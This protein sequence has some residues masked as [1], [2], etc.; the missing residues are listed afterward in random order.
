MIFFTGYNLILC[1]MFVIAYYIVPKKVRFCVLA[2]ASATFVL[3][4][5]PVRSIL[6]L[7]ASVFLIYGCAI[8][9]E[10][11]NKIIK[12]I[13]FVLGLVFSL[14]TMGLL[15]T[16]V[17]LT[18]LWQ[19]IL[20]PLGLSY[21]TFTM[22]GYLIDVKREMFKAEKNPVKFLLFAVFFP[23][24][25]SGPIINYEAMKDKLFE[26]HSFDLQKI[27]FGAQRIIWGLFK[28]IVISDRIGVVVNQIFDNYTEY[29]GFYII[30]AILF[31][32]IQ[33]YTDFSGCIDMIM[34]IA[35][36]FGVD[37]PDNFSLP[38]L[39][40]SVAEFWRRWHITLGNWLRDYVFYTILRAKFV[41]KLTKKFK[42]KVSTKKI[43]KYV[44]WCALLVTWF[45]IGLWHNGVPG[46]IFGVGIYFGVIIVLSEAT[47]GIRSK[48]VKALR[49]KTDCFSYDLFAI[50]RTYVL[51][52]VGNMFFRQR[53]GLMAGFTMLKNIFP[54][55]NI[56][57]F[58]DGSMNALG[59]DGFEWSILAIAIL[60]MIVAGLI[61]AKHEEGVRVWINNQNVLFSYLVWLVI[62]VLCILWGWY[63]EGYTSQAFIYQQF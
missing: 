16:F 5:N 43:M 46:S 63:G 10:K 44:T 23:T 1:C 39:S 56:W 62:I 20:A 51:F 48:A 60:I 21:Y 18:P 61:R 13:L 15:K 3:I 52:A 55:N 37:L 28:K 24:L 45:C 9:I 4:V 11:G 17:N 47:E 38:F 49:I 29:S 19:Y 53:A 12:N 25:L 32:P 30:I 31:F 41:K 7:F 57:I 22:M 34:G 50:C 54:L 40:K 33:L 42:Q 6:F 59:L 58:T 8:G 35:E 27:V 26:G 14:A 36:I 2:V